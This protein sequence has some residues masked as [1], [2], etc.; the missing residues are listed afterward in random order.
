MRMCQANLIHAFSIHCNLDIWNWVF[1][2]FRKKIKFGFNF[3][4]QMI[5]YFHEVLFIQDA[6]RSMVFM[7]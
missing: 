5:R 7:E 1:T 3:S 2:D 6:T 4:Y